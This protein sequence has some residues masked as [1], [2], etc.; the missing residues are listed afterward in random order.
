[1]CIL[2][3]KRPLNGTLGVK[4][5]TFGVDL[6][7]IQELVWGNWHPREVCPSS[8]GRANSPVSGGVTPR[9]I[10]EKAPPAHIYRKIHI[11]GAPNIRRISGSAGSELPHEWFHAENRGHGFSAGRELRYSQRS[12]WHIRFEWG[13]STKS[14]KT[15]MVDFRDAWAIYVTTMNIC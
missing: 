5:C 2:H 3:L 13:N 6:G 4:Q 1:V 8:A 15:S 9:E 12:C 14:G 10:P 7:G 11:L